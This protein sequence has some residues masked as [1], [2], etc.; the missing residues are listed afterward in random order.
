M[1]VRFYF[2]DRVGDECVVDQITAAT[3]KFK[4]W[5]VWYPPTD[6]RK[7]QVDFI[8]EDELVSVSMVDDI[9]EDDEGTGSHLKVV[10]FPG[11]DQHGTVS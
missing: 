4:Y 1:K 3:D 10:P 6:D 11:G 2:K 5:V 9:S 8:K 7:Q